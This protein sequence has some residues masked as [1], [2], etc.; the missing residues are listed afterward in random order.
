MATDEQTLRVAEIHGRKE[1]N[2]QLV[3]LNKNLDN[4]VTVLSDLKQVVGALDRH[5]MEIPAALSELREK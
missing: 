4:L 2:A 3:E 1:T 5:V